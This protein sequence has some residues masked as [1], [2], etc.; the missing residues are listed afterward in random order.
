MA[1]PSSALWVGALT[2]GTVAVARADDFAT[3]KYP[4]FLAE[5]FGGGDYYLVEETLEAS[6][7][8]V[9]DQADDQVPHFAGSEQRA[10]V[11]ITQIEA[12]RSE[13][14][15][16]AVNF[17]GY[18]QGGE[19]AR[20]ILKKRPDLL[21]SVTTVGTA[22][23]GSS[24]LADPFIVCATKQQLGVPCTAQEQGAFDAFVALGAVGGDP[25]A[26]I[27]PDPIGVLRAQCQ[28]SSG[29]NVLALAVCLAQGFDV[30]PTFDLKYPQGLP[31]SSCGEGPAFIYAPG[32]RKVHLF[33]WG[34][35]AVLTDPADPSDAVLQGTAAFQGPESD[36]LAERCSNHF[37]K[38]LR[39]D[40][41]WNHL[42]LINMREGLTGAS[43]PTVV[44]REHAH[45]L[46]LLGL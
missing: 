43:D 44:Y 15:V 9:C 35:T 27:P 42:D 31:L 10:A 39:D 16:S 28:F 2:I 17:I 34:G 4:I 38:V 19:D 29:T 23:R 14:G 13:H 37:G 11:L 33:S 5:G 12:C 3:T 26:P 20:V 46:K 7:A 24:G 6:G 25:D 36:G 30:G 21:A 40:H 41:P 32:F 22:H 45:R 18:S 1:R 8:T